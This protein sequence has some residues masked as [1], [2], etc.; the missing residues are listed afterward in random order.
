MHKKSVHYYNKSYALMVMNIP[1]LRRKYSKFFI[2][3]NLGKLTAQ[4]NRR[5][6]LGFQHFLLEL[7]HI[8]SPQIHERY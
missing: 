2:D 5:P 4:H 6:T 7:Q 3:L 1:Q 8:F